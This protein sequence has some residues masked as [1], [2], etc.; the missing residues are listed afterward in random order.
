MKIITVVGAR[1]NFMKAAPIVAAIRQHNHAVA[2]GTEGAGEMAAPAI[3]HILV[4]TGQHYDRAMSDSFF[5]DLNLPAPDIQLGVGSASHAVQTGEIL[6]KFE[7]VLLREQP[8][9]I[10]VVGDVNSTLACALVAAKISFDASGR[11]PL[12]AHVEAG[13]RSFDRSMPEEINRI[14]TDQLS[15][16]LFVT[17]ESAIQNLVN[18]GISPKSIHFV[19]NTM[20]DSVLAFQDKAENSTI[21]EQLKLLGQ[22]GDSHNGKSVARYALLTLHRPSNVDSRDAF[23][24]IM[25]GLSELAA[26]LPIVF[27]VH[28]RTRPRIQEFGMDLHTGGN[29][30]P[31]TPFTETAPLGLI[32]TDPLGYL[33]FLC[34]MK[35]ATIVLTDSG[36]VQ[37]E[38]TC[39]GIPCVTL[40]EN[41]ERPVTVDKGT[42][43][44]GGTTRESIETALR[45]QAERRGGKCMP[46]KWDGRA[47]T[48]ILDIIINTHLRSNQALPR[49]SV[50]INRSRNPVAVLRQTNG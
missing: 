44:I 23:L 41:T 20:I 40:R 7:A 37:E 17:E 36:G 11:R 32:L 18:E 3:D 5:S 26:K 38:T 45:R 49:I 21:L 28:P 14:L 46:E 19:G 31:G 1:P 15:D 24:G 12:V 33:D 25:A 10:I 42:N 6:T 50:P 22:E 2:S 30:T 34:L 48:R 4:H 35:H 13:L 47:A 8:D 27:P 16:L 39:L 29:T 43:V 9:L